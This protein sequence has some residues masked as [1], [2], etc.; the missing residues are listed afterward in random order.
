MA[1]NRGFV[2]PSQDLHKM[3]KSG[4]IQGISEEDFLKQVQPA[5]FEPT[6][7]SK[8]YC[9][10]N[11]AF[12][13]IRRNSGENIEDVLKHIPRGDCQELEIDEK[14]GLSLKPHFRYLIPQREQFTLESDETLKMSPKSSS[15]RIWFDTRMLSSASSRI[16]KIIGAEVHGK[17][18]DAWLLIEPL[19]TENIIYPNQAIGQVRITKGI[20]PKLT[21]RE[22]I[23]LHEKEGLVYNLNKEGK[24]A[25]IENPIFDNGELTTHLALHSLDGHQKIQSL[26]MKQGDCFILYGREYMKIPEGYCA[27]MKPYSITSRRGPLHFAG[28]FDP[29]FEGQPV[30]EIR[31]DEREWVLQHGCPIAEFEFY[32]LKSKPTLLG[33]SFIYGKKIGSNYSEQCGPRVAKHFEEKDLTSSIGFKA[34]KN[35]IPIDTKNIEHYSHLDYYNEVQ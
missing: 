5:S 15:G 30:V 7:G 8:A 32:K 9:I 12:Q 19:I 3:F 21:Q 31:C 22:L 17:N 33:E 23:D 13:T 10:T 14:K 29:G 20:D 11:D 6:V 18:I 24:L 26:R 1:T 34:R 35:P 25:R 28:F 2:L 4:R 16:D 27:E